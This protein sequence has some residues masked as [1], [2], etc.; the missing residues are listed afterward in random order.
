MAGI[1]EAGEWSCDEAG[2][3]QEESGWQQSNATGY[4]TLRSSL[5]QTR[6]PGTKS[7]AD[8]RTNSGTGE[9]VSRNMNQGGKAAESASDAH[10]MTILYTGWRNAEADF[11]DA[12][13]AAGSGV[14]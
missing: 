8:R 9:N 2:E 4:A 7:N 5:A 1:W 10:C 14:A 13:L 3:R 12:D 11:K 6:S